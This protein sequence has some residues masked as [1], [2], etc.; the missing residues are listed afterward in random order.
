MKKKTENLKAKHMNIVQITLNNPALNRKLCLVVTDV[1]K[2]KCVQTARSKH[3][4][5]KQTPGQDHI[6]ALIKCAEGGRAPGPGPA[7]PNPTM[8]P[9]QSLALG[10]GGW[11]RSD[12]LCSWMNICMRDGRAGTET[13]GCVHR[14]C[15]DNI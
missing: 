5:L 14:L 11:T 1:L 8:G 12:V 6:G 2:L 13:L 15:V 4:Q 7:D 9:H 10:D 3:T